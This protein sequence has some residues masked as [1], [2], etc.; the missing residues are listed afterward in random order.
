MSKLA[1]GHLS[2]GADTENKLGT[3]SGGMARSS[4]GDVPTAD[5]LSDCSRLVHL[6]PR[7]M[8]EEML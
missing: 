5:M 6:T 4:P 2:S 1:K 7:G 8:K 3:E